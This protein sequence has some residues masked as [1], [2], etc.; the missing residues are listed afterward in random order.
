MFDKIKTEHR[1]LF[2][3][4]GGSLYCMRL[5]SKHSSRSVNITTLKTHVQKHYLLPDGRT[6]L[7]ALP[8]AITAIPSSR[9]AVCRFTNAGR[10]IIKLPSLQAQLWR[11]VQPN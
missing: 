2:R 1:F 7:A 5:P 6:D 10:A 3:Q 9:H 4:F 11:E 8:V